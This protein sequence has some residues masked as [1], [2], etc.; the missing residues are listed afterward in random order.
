MKT[1]IEP[2]DESILDVEDYQVERA[3]TDAALDAIR[4]GRQ[5]G[6]DYVVWEDD[7]VKSL[8]PNETAPHEKQLLEELERH[9]RRIR[10][11]QAQKPN[12]LE[13]NDKP[14]EKS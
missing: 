14:G 3:L 9:N 7:R 6:T 4:R 13:L 5:F 10:E 2:W 12:A 11:L 1:T 8:K